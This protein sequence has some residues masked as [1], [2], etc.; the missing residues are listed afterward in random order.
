MRRFVKWTLWSLAGLAL[1]LG[2]AYGTLI[3]LARAS[4][5]T[6]STVLVIENAADRALFDLTVSHNGEIVHR[7]DRLDANKRMAIRGL[8]PLKG[9]SA[10]PVTD[11][12]YQARASAEIA[13]APIPNSTPIAHQV[14]VGGHLRGGRSR[15]LFV[16]R[17]RPLGAETSECVVQH[18][19]EPQSFPARS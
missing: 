8:N 10:A 3:F 7:Q 14:F 4:L 15:C 6:F 19:A 11:E 5:E 13:Y 17:I 2:L 1:L 16:I 12:V 18:L 9:P